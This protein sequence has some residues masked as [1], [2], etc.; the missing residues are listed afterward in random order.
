L[1]INNLFA[2][3]KISISNCKA[4]LALTVFLLVVWE[5]FFYLKYI[6]EKENNQLNERIT[7]LHKG[8]TDVRN[9]IDEALKQRNSL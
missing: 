9:Q 3:P 6:L 2:S 5:G 1:P 8:I 7:D 4:I